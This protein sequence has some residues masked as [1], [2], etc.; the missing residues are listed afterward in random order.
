M[1]VYLAKNCRFHLGTASGGSDLVHVFDTPF[2][3]VNWEIGRGPIKNNEIFIPKTIKYKASGLEVAFKTQ[4]EKIGK[5]PIEFG[6]CPEEILNDLGMEIIDNTSG[7]ILE[8]VKE[9]F[10]RM[11]GSWVV[12]NAYLHKRQ[13][14][15]DILNYYHHWFA[16][17]HQNSTIGKDF[18]MKLDLG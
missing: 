10:S 1:D 2:V 5:I 12:S 7:Q 14:Y 17:A 18:L 8:L 11:D 16:E 13:E 4:I 3:G 6:L 9:M 15:Q